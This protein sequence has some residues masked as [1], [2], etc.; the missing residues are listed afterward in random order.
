M[1]FNLFG[2]LTIKCIYFSQGNEEGKEE[3]T[4]MLYRPLLK[5]RCAMI[6]LS[7]AFK[8]NEPKNTEEELEVARQCMA[9]ATTLEMDHKPGTLARIGMMIQDHLDDLL[10]MPP[11]MKPR[12]V[13]VGE[14]KVTVG[15]KEYEFDVPAGLV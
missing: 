9:I 12:G 7:C 1:I 4:L 3:P 2:D 13:K 10:K 14:G 11:R 15:G 8:Y 5:G 6:P